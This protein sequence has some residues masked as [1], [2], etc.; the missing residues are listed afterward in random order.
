MNG[1]GSAHAW[2]AWRGGS[3]GVCVPEVTRR[4]DIGEA[5]LVS[6]EYSSPERLSPRDKEP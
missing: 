6:E 1:A 2:R 4:W 3:A 5:W